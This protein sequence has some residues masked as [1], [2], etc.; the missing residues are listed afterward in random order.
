MSLVIRAAART[1]PAAIRDR[2]REQWLADARDATEAGLHP[3]SIALAAVSFAVTLDRP[4]PSRRVPTAQQ[5]AQR[6]RLGVGL[7]LSAALLALSQY[8]RIGFSGLTSFAIWDF[9][10]FF[11]SMVLVAYAVLAPVAALV[12]VR[13][14]RQRWAVILLAIATTAPVAAGLGLNP[15]DDSYLNGLPPFVIAAVLIAASCALLWRPNG[16]SLRAPLI[17]GLAVWG[18]TASGLAYGAGIAWPARTLPVY[19]LQTQEYYAEWLQ[20]KLQ[21]EALV[22]QTFVTWAIAGSVFGV[23]VFAFGRRMSSRRATALGI[24][25]GTIS[26]LGAS[27]VFGLLELGMS[28]TVAEPLLDPLRLIAQVVLVAVTLISVGGVRYLPRVGHRHDVEG[29]VELVEG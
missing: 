20:L 22:D 17:S 4:L 11:V 28:G 19:G 18:I 3:A 23:L 9:M 2:Y 27:G 15:S 26:L 21:F 12:L 24:A 29:A 25:A 7:A 10:D 13:G 16:R 6:S 5:R 8:P 1:L 14:G